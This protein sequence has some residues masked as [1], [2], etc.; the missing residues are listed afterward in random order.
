M[1]RNCFFFVWVLV[2]SVDCYCADSDISIYKKSLDAFAWFVIVISLSYLYKSFSPS[3]Y[4]L[5]NFSLS[6]KRKPRLGL[7]GAF[8]RFMSLSAIDI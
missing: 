7:A 6:Y 4:G 2:G 5:N 1:G 3:E 8:H